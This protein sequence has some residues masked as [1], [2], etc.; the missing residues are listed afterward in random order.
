MTDFAGE[1]WYTDGKRV[2]RGRGGPVLCTLGD[3]AQGSLFEPDL[4]DYK[5]AQL[6]ACAPRLMQALEECAKRLE[7]CCHFS[8]SAAEYS[9]LAVKGYRDLIAEAR[10]LPPSS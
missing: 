9:V 5:Y 4:T 2:R 3:P 10:G 7:T 6:I 1:H 8:G